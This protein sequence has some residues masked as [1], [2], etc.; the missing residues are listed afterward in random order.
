MADILAF[1]QFAAARAPRYVPAKIVGAQ[2][3]ITVRI[4]SRAGSPHDLLVVL[5][6]TPDGCTTVAAAPAGEMAV[7]EVIAYSVLAALEVAEST[8]KSQET[9]WSG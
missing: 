8:W 2:S 1:P 6:G 9:A 5:E 3:G 4:L 7:A